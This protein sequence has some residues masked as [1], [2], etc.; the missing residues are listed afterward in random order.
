MSKAIRTD[1]KLWQAV[2][3]EVQAG[4]KGGKPGTWSARKAQFAVGEYKS[5]GGKYKGKKSPDNS[6]IIWTKEDWDY[7]LDDEDGRYLPKSVRQGMSAAEKKK[8]N[9]RKK[10]ASRK[11][12]RRATYS[13]PTASRMRKEKIGKRKPA[14]K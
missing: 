4:S 7:V 1:E 5:R 8:T 12:S 6:L 9:S 14:G 11:G 13:V 2:K 10:K 3:K